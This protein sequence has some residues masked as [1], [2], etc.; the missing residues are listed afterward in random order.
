LFQTYA[1]LTTVQIAL[2]TAYM[3]ILYLGSGAYSLWTPEESLIFKRAGERRYP[4]I[5]AAR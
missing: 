1:S 4:D 2:A 3:L 5:E